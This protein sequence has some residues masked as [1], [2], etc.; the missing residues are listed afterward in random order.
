MK[1]SVVIPIYKVEQ[2]L[3]ECLQN[4]LSQ[5]YEDLEIILV[6]D[7]SPDNCPQLCDEYAQRDNRI[8]VIHKKN[9]GLSDA[10]NAGL[11]AATGNYI[12]FLDSDDYWCDKNLIAGLTNEIN[13]NLSTDIVLFRRKDFYENSNRSSESPHF[14]T[15][16]VNGKSRNDVFRYLLENQLFNMSA[17]FQIIRRELLI[18][19]ELF[20]EKGQLGEDLDWSFRLWLQAKNIRAINTIGYCYRHRTDSIT[21]T[22]SIQNVEDFV[23]VLEKWQQESKKFN[24]AGLSQIYLGYV[25]HLYPTLLRNYFLIEK[26]YRKQEYDLLKKLIPVMQY[27]FTPKARQVANMYKFVG[28]QFSCLF[29][30]LWGLVRK[31]GCRQGLTILVK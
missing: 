30:G 13:K 19:N 4:V 7:G 16:F 3:D 25:A 10:R 14:D 31:K 9:G 15:D 27:A 8:K 17:C 12:L 23:T 24:D 11:K 6:D 1:V 18:S 28:F 22:Y 21:T 26:K 29:F 5:T 20:F 2:Y